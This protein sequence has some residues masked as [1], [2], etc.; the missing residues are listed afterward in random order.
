MEK[1]KNLKQLPEALRFYSKTHWDLYVGVLQQNNPM[2]QYLLPEDKD[3]KF[4]RDE[5]WIQHTSR[6]TIHTKTNILHT[7]VL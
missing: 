1:L 2:N 7:Q 3:Q 6:T 5:S 4:Q